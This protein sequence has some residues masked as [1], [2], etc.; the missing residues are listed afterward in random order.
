V[1]E[2]VETRRVGRELTGRQHHL[3]IDN[4]E[5]EDKEG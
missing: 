2:P 1:V 5:T 4:F 3:D